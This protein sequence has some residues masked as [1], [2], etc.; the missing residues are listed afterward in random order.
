[1]E[2]CYCFVYQWTNKVNNKKYI[3]SHTG[4]I[5]DGYI[6]S[7]TIFRKAIKKYGI[8]NFERVI[9]E[10]LDTT[11]RKLLL[12]REKFWLDKTNA[13]LDDNYYNVAQDVIGG[14]TRAGW[15]EER[16]KEF[17]DQIKN[18]WAARDL[19]ERRQI[20][21]HAKK[22]QE[23]LHGGPEQLK[24]WKSEQMK[25]NRKN[26]PKLTL[27]ERQL[28]AKKGL[29]TLGEEGIR[30]RAEKS[31]ANRDPEKVK[32]GTKKA[33]AKRKITM[34]N[35]SPEEK[36]E[37]ASKRS[38][39]LKG[40]FTGSLNHNAKKVEINGVVYNTFNEALESLQIK[41]SFLR[42]RLQSDEFPTWNYVNKK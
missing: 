13:A 29:E 14:N 31:R 3:G 36:R 32:E 38:L 25:K 6:G 1:M 15:S 17:S 26:F 19:V 10:K 9:L 40:R 2:E 24:L 33:V 21:S 23:D 28:A 7:G 5:N 41:E 34:A 18:I 39:S 16:K 12:E 22:A 4:H 8:E 42:R 20:L 35:R 30:K 27:E 37:T 11:D